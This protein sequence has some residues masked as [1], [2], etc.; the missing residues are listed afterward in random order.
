MGRFDGRVA[1]VTGAA[2][3]IGEATAAR[4]AAEGASVLA[5]DVDAPGLEA[6]AAGLGGGDRVRTHAADVSDRPACQAAVDAAVRAFGKLDAVVNCAGINRFHR[7]EDMPA[8]DWHRILAV[9]LTGVAFVCQAA[10]PRL[11]ETRGVIV[12]VASVA[13]LKGQAYT[14]AYC[15]SKGGVVQLTRA[16]AMEYVDRGVRINA[17]APGGVHTPMSR[18]LRFPPEMDWELVKP[19]IGRRGL[20]QP[21]EIA[22]AIAWLAS[23]EA[24]FVHGAVLAMDGGITA[25]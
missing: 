1:L 6:A 10:L 9:N 19:Y 18:T 7:F 16:L 5:V 4:F 23:D 8:E 21:Q 25:G 12:N 22:G 15:A 2:S 20:C 24:A 3:G 17:I 14:V 11:L 13:G